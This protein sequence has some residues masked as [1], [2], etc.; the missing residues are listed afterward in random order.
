MP[1]VA[2]ILL[3]VPTRERLRLLGRS[4]PRLRATS[5]GPRRAEPPT[6]FRAGGQAALREAVRSDPPSA[7][8]DGCF[9]DTRSRLRAVGR[10][11]GCRP[12]R[13]RQRRGSRGIDERQVELLRV[14]LNVFAPITGRPS[15]RAKPLSFVGLRFPVASRHVFSGAARQSDG[16]HLR[17]KEDVRA[18]LAG[19][20]RFG[21]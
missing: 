17:L 9:R 3:R 6:R 10:R 21:A 4:A 16:R 18:H 1:N 12:A 2:W 20:M 15:S 14:G 11:G 5:I 19:V 8:S 13:L 7:R